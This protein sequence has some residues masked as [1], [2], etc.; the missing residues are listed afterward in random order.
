[1]QTPIS[2]G[3]GGFQEETNL[4]V[5]APVTEQDPDKQQSAGGPLVPG[6]R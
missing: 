2:L 4:A 6:R 1:M 3:E 5:W